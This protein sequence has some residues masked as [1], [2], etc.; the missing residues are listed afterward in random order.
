MQ[1]SF[2]VQVFIKQLKLKMSTS[3]MF[4][5]FDLFSLSWTFKC[6]TP[7]SYNVILIHCTCCHI[8]I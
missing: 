4:D 1:I 7:P 3:M 8:L 2:L 6:E 5:V